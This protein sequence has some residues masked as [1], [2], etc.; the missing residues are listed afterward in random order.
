[1]S[2]ENPS[3]AVHHTRLGH[4][5]STYCLH[6]DHGSCRL[7]CKICEAPCRCD[8]HASEEDGP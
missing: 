6:E 3:D 4:Y 2:V 7:T 1:M 8:C 5:L